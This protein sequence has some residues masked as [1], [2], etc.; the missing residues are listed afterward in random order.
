M[1]PEHEA[2]IK[3]MQRIIVEEW[4]EDETN[5]FFLT[6]IADNGS[7]AGLHHSLGRAIRNNYNLWEIPHT[8][9][10]RNGIDYSPEHPD[11]I[12]DT[13]LKELWNRGLPQKETL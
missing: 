1:R 2:I 13:L 8:P 5:Q 4:N 6:G 3:D 12:S 11:A 10:I 7:M 9:D